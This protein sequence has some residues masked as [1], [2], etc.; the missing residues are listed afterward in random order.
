MDDLISRQAAIDA[1]SE[2]PYGYRGIVWDILKSL[3]SAKQPRTCEYW[4][5]ESNY[6]TLNRPSAEPE[7]WHVL[8]RRP[9]D[10]DERKEW[11]ERFGYDI[12]YDDAYIYSNLPDYSEE[13]IICTH[14]GYV[15]T[16]RYYDDNDGSYF[17]SY[18][19]SDVM[20]WMPLP[21]PYKGGDE[22]CTT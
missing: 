5:N 3:P 19:L 9:M 7:Q 13:V 10:E 11:S 22:S 8:S 12:E 1:I 4:D 20:A 16:D 15:R 21:K 14:S 17:D 2:L 6:C 18:D